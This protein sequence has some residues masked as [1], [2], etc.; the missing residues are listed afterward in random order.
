MLI[1]YTSIQKITQTVNN[2]NQLMTKFL[3]L[4]QRE[5]E[6]SFLMLNLKCY[7]DTFEALI[8]TL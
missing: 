8:T 4:K 7:S 1:L 5:N 2:T 6:S 3:K